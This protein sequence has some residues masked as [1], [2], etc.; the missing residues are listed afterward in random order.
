MFKNY[1]KDERGNALIVA[2]LVMALTV[3]MVTSFTNNIT[4]STKIDQSVSANEQAYL[5]ARTGM[6]LLQKEME[7]DRQKV[8]DATMTQDQYVAKYSNKTFSGTLPDY[9]SFHGT[10]VPMNDGTDRFSITCY[11]VRDDSEFQLYQYSALPEEEDDDDDDRDGSEVDRAAIIT[12]GS[13]THLNGGVSGLMLLLGSGSTFKHQNTTSIID[14][15]ACRGNVNIDS[16]SAG[17]YGQIYTLSDIFVQR[18]LVINQG[19]WCKNFNIPSSTSGVTIKGPIY[20]IEDAKIEST[21]VNKFEGSNASIY[22]G[23]D[24]YLGKDGDSGTKLTIDGDIYCGGD[25]YVYAGFT[26]VNG[27]IYVKGNCYIY[28][29]TLQDVYCAGNITYDGNHYSYYQNAATVKSLNASGTITIVSRSAGVGSSNDSFDINEQKAAFDKIA[30]IKKDTQDEINNKLPTTNKPITTVPES[31]KGTI[32]TGESGFSTENGYLMIDHSCTFKFDPKTIFD[33]NKKILIKSTS[34]PVDI[35]IDA[36]SFTFPE[37]KGYFLIDDNGHKGLVRIFLGTKVTTVNAK[38]EWPF[39]PYESNLP[40]LV[41]GYDKYAYVPNVYIFQEGTTVINATDFFNNNGNKTCISAYWLTPYM[42]ISH[43]ASN[44]GMSGV[45]SGSE[46]TD[47]NC[48]V[49][50]SNHP[51]IHGMVTCDSFSYGQN[52]NN[53]FIKYHDPDNVKDVVGMTAN[54]WKYNSAIQNVY[55]LNY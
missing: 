40:T 28:G 23:G 31:V 24:V 16:T 7:L 55:N 37:G 49:T 25:L 14:V 34:D 27:K 11:G 4:T 44:F 9:G 53:V 8:N 29:G 51:A 47:P 1:V 26:T 33:Q 42:H 20:A 13:E 45:A 15:L 17:T 3:I 52:D 54:P 48:P 10:I 50:Q 22:A 43:S 36:D 19:A 5:N 35:Y 6:Q 2:L 12:Y 46:G 30:S 32:I 38:A 39:M 21:G 41:P 18:S